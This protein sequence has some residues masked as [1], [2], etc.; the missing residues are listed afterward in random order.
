MARHREVDVGVPTSWALVSARRRE[1]RGRLELMYRRNQTAEG[2]IKMILQHQRQ[3]EALTDEL[4]ERWA[5]LFQPKTWPER[6]QMLGQMHEQL[7][8]DIGDLEIYSSVSRIF[9]KKLIDRL[10]DGRP[11]SSTA[12]AHVYANSDDQDHRQAAGEWLCRLAPTT[13]S[14]A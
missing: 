5:T 13:N 3:V 4:V 8:D 11:V 12:Q 14:E 2:S 1:C 10:D 9:I 7:Q 6:L